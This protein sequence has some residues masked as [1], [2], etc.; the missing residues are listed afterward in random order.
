MSRSPS[1]PVLRRV[2]PASCI[3]ATRAPHC[4]V[5]CWRAVPARRAVSCCASKTPTRSAAPPL[6][7][8]VS[9]TICAGWASTGMARWCT[10]RT[11][12]C[13][14]ARARHADRVGLGL[15]LLLHPGRAR[16]ATRDADLAAGKPPRYSGRCRD[17]P[18]RGRAARLAAGEPAAFRFRVPARARSASMT[19]CTDR[20]V[21][22]APIGDFVLRRAD[23]G[24]R[25]S[26]P[27]PSTTRRA[28]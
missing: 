1:S 13:L 22:A 23:G 26:S 28:A 18:R 11:R 20:C 17:L 3:S 21:S 9:W 27:M 8:P 25:S 7:A 15:S 4:S 19:S 2:P 12:R 14:R 5:R 10:S 24:P 6:S 16:T